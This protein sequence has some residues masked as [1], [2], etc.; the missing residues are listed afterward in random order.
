MPDVLWPYFE[1]NRYLLNYLAKIAA[2]TVMEV[3]AQRGLKI[4]VFTALHTFG[5]DLKWNV[6]VHLSVTMGGLTEDLQ[7]WKNIR[8]S[9]KVVMPK[10]RE[11]IIELLRNEAKKDNFYISNRTLDIEYNK[12]WRVKFSEPTGDAQ[13]TIAYLGR[14]IKRPPLS[15]SRLEHYDGKSVTFNYL[16]HRNKQHENITFSAEDFIERFVKH[17]PDT[18]FR[19]IRYYGFLAN[20]VRSKLLPKVYNLV[21]HEDRQ[22]FNVNWANLLK[23]SFGV[24]PLKCILCGKAMKLVGVV[25]GKTNSELWKYHKELAT[26]QIIPV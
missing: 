3:A 7:K 25:F 24:D 16:N 13:H 4:G 26:R 21:G 18:G 22:V 14:Y 12:Y 15:M 20:S 1:R 9:E 19:M 2:D 10:W 17:I 8:F 23:V 6:H 5:R 11:K